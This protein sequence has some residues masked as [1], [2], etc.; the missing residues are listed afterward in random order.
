MSEQ[1]PLT[2]DQTSISRREKEKQIHMEQVLK[3]D[4]DAEEEIEHK[5]SL[6]SSSSF[7]ISIKIAFK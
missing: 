5:W 6:F 2:L 1:M 7:L 4:D 3:E